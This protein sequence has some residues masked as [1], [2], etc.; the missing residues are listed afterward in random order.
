MEETQVS[1]TLLQ[2]ILVALN[3]IPNQVYGGRRWQTTYQL[4]AEL[5]RVLKTAPDGKPS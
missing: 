4:A 1:R 5:S 2:E 3:D